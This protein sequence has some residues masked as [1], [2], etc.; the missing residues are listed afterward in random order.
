M[1][2][3]PASRRELKNAFSKHYHVYNAMDQSYHPMTRRLLL[4]YAVESGLKCYLLKNIHKYMTSELY[5]YKQFNDLQEHGHDIRRL[6]KFAGISGQKDYQLG[7]LFMKNGDT[8][9]P[10]Q[11]HQL[12][13]YGIES[14]VL[15]NE[16]RIE[17]T[18]KNIADWLSSNLVE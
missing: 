10:E 14:R 13:R 4:F 16:D 3:I 6:V 2:Q 12:W 18:L 15:E 11:F 9:A 17:V 5:T 8:I 1:A 7:N